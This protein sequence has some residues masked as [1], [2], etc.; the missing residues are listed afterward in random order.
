SSMTAMPCG[1]KNKR[2]EMIHSQTVTP[3]LAAIDGTTFRLN[4][5]TTNSSTRSRRPRARIRWGWAAVCV[6]SDKTRLETPRFA[7]AN[8]RGGCLHMDIEGARGADECVRPCTKLM[9]YF[10]RNAFAALLL[11]FRQAR[12]DV[13]EGGKVLVDV[14]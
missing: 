4:T 7:W 3:P 12:R 10:G 9:R 6:G 11:R 8:S 13:V 2:R 5:A 1:Q 14:G